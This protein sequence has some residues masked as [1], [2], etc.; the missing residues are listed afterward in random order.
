M[1]VEV[2]FGTGGW[3]WYPGGLQAYSREHDF[4]EL[5]SSYYR[6]PD[7]ATARGWRMAVPEKFEFSAVHPRRREERTGFQ[8]VLKVLRVKYVVVHPTTVEREAAI[9]ELSELG[10]IPVIETRTGG[11][12]APQ[13]HSIR[14]EDPACAGRAES[15]PH[16]E[17]RYLRV[18]GSSRGVLDHLG[19]QMVRKVSSVV[20]T[21]SGQKDGPSVRVVVHTYSMNA[22]I[23]RIA[24]DART[25]G[26]GQSPAT[27]SR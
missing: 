27:A 14:T 5:N 2:R 1:E 10:Y 11:W 20:R 25:E 22:D 4:V 19:G 17:D 3:A 15:I 21:L 26:S 6:S 8:E 24:M 13:V 7:P 23:A 16:P 12:E 9:A 18:F